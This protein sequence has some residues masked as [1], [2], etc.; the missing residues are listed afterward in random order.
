[1]QIER[2]AGDVKGKDA[3]VGRELRLIDMLSADEV[4]PL[5]KVVTAGGLQAAA[6]T[7][8]KGR[9]LWAE[10]TAPEIEAVRLSILEDIRQ[11][12]T[13]GPCWKVSS[14]NY[15][16]E[17]IGFILLYFP[18]PADEHLLS[19]LLG[20]VSTCLTALVRNNAKRIMT[21]EIHT[22]VVD[23][24]FEELVESNRRLSASEKKYREL[25]ASLQAK[26]DEKTSELKKAFSRMLRQE[27]LSSIG[28]LAAGMAHEIN[29]PIGF[30]S[31]NLNTFA[32]YMNN[33]A[34]MIMFYRTSSKGTIP[35]AESLY[36]KLKI[37]FILND[38]VDLINQ[39]GQGA[40]RI[41]EI[42]S[43]LKDFS[44]VDDARH[45]SVDLAAEL[46]KVLN[47]L[48][49]QI[50]EK[51]VKVIRT[52]GSA[53]TIEGNPADISLAFHNI[54]VNALASRDNGLIV[55]VT[56]GPAGNGA[57]V[58]ISDNGPGIPEAIRSRIFEPFFSTQEIGKGMG[59][60]LTIA[61]DIISSL[62]GDIE[63][64]S[65]EGKGSAF[66]ITFPIRK[67]SA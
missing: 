61:Y 30:I 46:D 6:V 1:M 59:M 38:A 4:V 7:D 29:N 47:V 57:S 67:I 31:S 49:P 54:L 24:S 55:S 28:Q 65:E 52:Y 35:Q 25:S 66:V 19:T 63:V 58:I 43:N 9:V 53:P 27:K 18:D 44:H 34:E 62:G 36:I 17:T 11:G 22:A 10:S 8:E 5:L 64:R 48:S 20:T 23:Q 39:S 50:S 45:I 40:L 14:L 37:D 12:R 42:V 13:S 21:T 16:G 32:K 56:T 41:K 15:E 3:A 2:D 33:I 51:S 60:G 26:V